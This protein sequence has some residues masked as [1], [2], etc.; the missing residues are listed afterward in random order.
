MLKPIDESAEGRIVRVQTGV[1]DGRLS[2]LVRIEVTADDVGDDLR[3]AGHLLVGAGQAILDRAM[4]IAPDA[5]GMGG[6]DAG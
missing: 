1:Q 4:V 2:V 6:D 3:E 5:L